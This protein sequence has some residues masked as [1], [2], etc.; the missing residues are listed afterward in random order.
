[1]KKKVIIIGA[2]PAGIITAAYLL[3]S[4]IDVE[5][6]EK[7]VFPRL[8]VGESLLPVSLD[9]FE[10]LDLMPLL[11]KQGYQIKPGIRFY[12]EKKLFEFS[13]SDQFT[14]NAKTYTWQ[15]PRADFDKVLAD[16]ISNRGAIINYGATIQ[17]LSIEDQVQIKFK[18]DGKDHIAKGDF[19]VDAS[20]FG[21][22]VPNLLNQEVKKNQYP[23]WACFTHV[24]D[25]RADQFEEPSRISFD[26]IAVDLWFW[27]IPFSNG[28]TSIGFSGHKRHFD[29]CDDSPEYFTSLLEK[30]PQFKDRFKGLPYKF[31]PRWH[32]GF[33]QAATQMYGDKYVL[34]GN[35]LEFLD[36]VFSSGVA[37]ATASAKFAS[38]QI[39]K[40]L[41]NE[42]ADWDEYVNK[43]KSGIDVFK[44]YVESWYTGELQEIIFSK[45]FNP[46][47]QQQICSVLAGYV[48]D[49]NNNFAK[50]HKR[51]L[52][53]LNRVIQLAEND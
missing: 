7:S 52:K 31:D 53:A 45:Q 26:I 19:L 9:H 34:V 43:I 6:I 20:G 46:G 1:M 17:S 13:F 4:G 44:T 11:E 15:V 50:K 29:K 47:F 22:V 30:T 27:M 25:T 3:K 24:Q 33:S 32:K 37:L 12:R 2:G 16:E 14:E 5:I 39:I 21:N 8:V 10:E 38:E 28:T 48:W 35:T 40:E 36:P 42:Q 41:S 23:N 18:K 49:K 51:A